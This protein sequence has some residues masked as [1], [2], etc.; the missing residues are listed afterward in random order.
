[1]SMKGLHLSEEARRKISMAR[2][3]LHPSDETLQ[4]MSKA[5]KGL[6]HSVGTRQKMSAALKGHRHSD[7]TRKKLSLATKRYFL[8]EEHRHKV[9]E[10]MKGRHLSEEHRKSISAA[11]KGRRFSKEARQ[12]IS[13]AMKGRHFSKEWRQKISAANK[14]WWSSAPKQI[15]A[16]RV[17]S[18][19]RALEKMGLLPSSLECAMQQHFNKVGVVFE[20][21]KEFPPYFVDIW[22][23]ELNLAVECDGVYWHNLPG[24]REKERKR[25]RYLIAR[26]KICVVR[27]P[28]K[29]I[30]SNPEQVVSEIMDCML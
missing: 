19:H 2:K 20:T 8:S 21:Q 24:A 30:R 10:R 9:S 1:M 14:K 29:T 5:H 17:R 4:K 25:D 6:H 16:S 23:P 22:I 26:Y 27:V 18:M 7:E 28:E 3:G 11:G 15:T 13:I 12:K